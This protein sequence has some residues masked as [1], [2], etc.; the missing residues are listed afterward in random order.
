MSVDNCRLFVGG[1][2]KRVNKEN[3]KE[4]MERVTEGVT[5][6]IMYPSASDKT[7]NRG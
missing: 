6:I 2:P 5:D 4:E 1:I 3:I 7:K